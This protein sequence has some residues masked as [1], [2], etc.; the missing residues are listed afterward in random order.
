MYISDDNNINRRQKFVS[1]I[2]NPNHCGKKKKPGNRFCQTNLPE[3]FNDLPLR[4]F[5]EKV[6]YKIHRIW[7]FGFRVKKYITNCLLLITYKNYFHPNTQKLR[8]ATLVLH[9]FLF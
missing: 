5:C 9:F 1:F 3:P 6:F 7:S 8:E 2:A 4:I